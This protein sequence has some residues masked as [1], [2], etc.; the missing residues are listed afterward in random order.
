MVHENTQKKVKILSKKEILP[1][2]LEYID[3]EQI[4][5]YYGGKLDY[6]GGPDNCRFKNPLVVEMNN[7]VKNINE[8]LTPE[9]KAKLD[10]AKFDTHPSLAPPGLPGDNVPDKTVATA[11]ASTAVNVNTNRPPLPPPVTP[12]VT[13]SIAAPNAR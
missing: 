7:F 5:E 12:L 13:N 2:L 11:A 8:R 1:G 4:P 3:I 9:Q 10:E 6:G